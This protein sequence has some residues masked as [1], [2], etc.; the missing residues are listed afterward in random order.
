MTIN[1]I[2]LGVVSLVA[3]VMGACAGKSDQS[4]HRGN[5][6]RCNDLCETAANCAGSAVDKSECTDECVDDAQRASD[7]CTE[8]FEDM[9][10]CMDDVNLSCDDATDECEN[11]IDDWADDCELDF[12]DT[13]GTLVGPGGG[14]CNDSCV[15]SYDGFC[16]EPNICPIGTDAYDCGC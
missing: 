3:L 2:L 14:S 12:E 9:A 8:S 16:D 6:D 11:Q 5:R 13:L 4:D 1:R 15:Y 7:S 10:D